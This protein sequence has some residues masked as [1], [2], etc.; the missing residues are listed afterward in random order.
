MTDS[1]VNAPVSINEARA[2]KQSNASLWTVRDMLI[3]CLRDIDN[4]AEYEASVLCLREKGKPGEGS[5]YKTIYWQAG[6]GGMHSSLG[7]LA[8]VSQLIGNG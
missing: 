2:D 4:G 6:P 7:L 1:F 3:A 8:R 5:G